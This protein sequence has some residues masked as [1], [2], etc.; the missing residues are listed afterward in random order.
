MGA[1]FEGGYFFRL[2]GLQR[3]TGG[4]RHQ[5]GFGHLQVVVLGEIEAEI[6]GHGLGVAQFAVDDHALDAVDDRRHAPRRIVQVA[7]R[8]RRRPAGT[9]TSRPPSVRPS[10]WGEMSGHPG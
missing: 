2:R 7:A 9:S 10:R 5:A 1:R 8:L 4:V 6:P 3:R